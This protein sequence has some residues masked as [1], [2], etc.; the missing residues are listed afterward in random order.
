M[1]KHCKCIL[2]LTPLVFYIWWTHLSKAAMAGRTAHKLK[3][4]ILLSILN[5]PLVIELVRSARRTP[6]FR[7]V[8]PRLKKNND[9]G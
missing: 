7:I 2:H 4:V 9:G 5:P 3:L 8:Q 6:Y 1:Y